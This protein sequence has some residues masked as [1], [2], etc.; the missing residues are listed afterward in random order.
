M[1]R[2]AVVVEILVSGSVCGVGMVDTEV[3]ASVS[4]P[5]YKQRLEIKLIR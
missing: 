1:L 4:G 5:Q 3:N 2:C